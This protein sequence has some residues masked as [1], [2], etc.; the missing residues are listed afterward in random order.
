M[1]NV[2]NANVFF[3]HSVRQ[4]SDLRANIFIFSR[5]LASISIENK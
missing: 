5:L 2:M 3:L 4:L 1:N